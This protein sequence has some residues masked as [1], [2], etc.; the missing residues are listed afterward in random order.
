MTDITV[1]GAAFADIKGFS[2]GVYHGRERNLGDIIISHGGVCRNVAENISGTG[3]SVRFVSL[4]DDSV[5]GREVLERLNGAGVDTSYVKAVPGG[6]G[7]W[8]AVMNERRDIAGQI[9]KMPDTA[10]LERIIDEHGDEIF[11]DTKSAVM[12][13]D[14][15]ERITE[16]V[17]ALAKHH[18]V[19]LYTV[20]GNLSVIMKRPDFLRSLACIVCNE[21]EIGRLCGD[22]LSELSPENMLNFIVGLS[23][24]EQYPPIII[25]MG[26]NGAVYYDR[27]ANL[28]GICPPIKSKVIDTS[29]AGD[30]FL[31]GAVVGFSRGLTIDKACEIGTEM[32]HYIIETEESSSPNMRV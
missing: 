14:T 6:M 18:G 3:L 5:L 31:S 8:L 16:K 15:G 32:A 20:V 22:D 23:D 21:A 24:R 29:G 28:R 4:V 10:E 11:A 13:F 25:T 2:R 17:I 19:K 9:S 27:G 12:E 7:M 30:A 1:I 26:E